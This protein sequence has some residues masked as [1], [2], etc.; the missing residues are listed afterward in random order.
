[1][2]V[3]EGKILYNA[4]KADNDAIMKKTEKK[5]NEKDLYFEYLER[6]YCLGLM[7]INGIEGDFSVKPWVKSKSPY[8]PYCFFWRR[9]GLVAYEFSKKGIDWVKS[10]LNLRIK[11]D[12]RENG[13]KNYTLGGR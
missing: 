4:V 6:D 9:N 10:Q 11:E 12:K 2:G 3:R 8:F 13:K 7:E 5:S 1:M